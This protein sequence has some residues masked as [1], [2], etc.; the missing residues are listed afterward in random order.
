MSATNSVPAA[1]WV[2]A[3]EGH[4]FDIARAEQLL[5]PPFDP[6]CERIPHNG[7]LVWALRSRSFDNLRTAEEV[8]SRAVELMALLNGALSVSGD[9]EPLRLQSIGQIDD[10]GRARFTVFA[11]F[12]GRARGDMLIGTVDVRDSQGNL[13]PPP[14]PEP[15]AA[16]K[17]IAT[18]AGN[19]TVADMLIF[20][21][22]AD[23]WFDIFKTI[24]AAGDLVGGE[25][26]LQKLLG[27]SGS[28]F[29]RMRQTANNL[30]RHRP[31]K[32]TTPEAPTTAGRCEATAGF[33]CEDG[34][35]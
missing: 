7:S 22:R 13:V 3:I 10:E 17:W 20:A 1:G 2:A 23:N 19:D 12:H 11:A 25:R 5:K 4:T 26:E 21:G 34:Y 29:K 27:P 6:H 16:Q 35:G 28:A 15:S 8:H 32:F 30:H 18:A 24:E 31:G 33:H 9:T 14:P